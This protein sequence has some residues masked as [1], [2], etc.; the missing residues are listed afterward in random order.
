MSDSDDDWE[1]ADVPTFT[2][3]DTAAIA[4]AEAAEAARAKAAE[5]KQAAKEAEVVAQTRGWEKSAAEKLKQDKDS[6]PMILVD[7]T[8]L[9][10]GAIHNEFDKNGV[11]DVDAKR[12]LQR[13]VESS[14]G[15]YANDAALIAAGTVRAC[16][17]GVYRAALA[18][19]R[20][21]VPGHFWAAIFPP[22]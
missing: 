18:T 15:K 10:N 22:P 14:Y 2:K 5:E 4:A 11:N 9:S 20:D 7:F 3:V 6:K 13:E 21:E 8:V 19:L 17:Q 12:K 16:S 1:T